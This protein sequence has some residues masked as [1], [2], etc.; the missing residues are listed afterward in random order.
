MPGGDR[1]G[2]MGAGPKTG[3][4][5]GFCAGFRVPGYMNTGYQAGN[6]ASIRGAGRGGIPWGG[7][8]GRVWGGG[9]GG[10]GGNVYRS[11]R[12][13][14]QQ[15][16]DNMMDP[17]PNEQNTTE[18]GIFEELMLEINDLKASIESLENRIKKIEPTA[19]TGK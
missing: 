2:P 15:M 6:Y 17:V 19:N 14:G 7:G 10:F 18:A 5:A 3:R 1:S 16:Y 4:A 11:R 13:Y 9:Q 12:G 8:R